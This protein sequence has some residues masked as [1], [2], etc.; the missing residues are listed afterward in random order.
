MEAVA[1]NRFL[2]NGERGSL[3]AR[4]CDCQAERLGRRSQA[5]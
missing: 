1:T 4:V 3:E 5:R 2:D